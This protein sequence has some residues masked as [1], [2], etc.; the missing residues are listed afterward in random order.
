MAKSATERSRDWRRKN[1]KKGGRSL[2]VWLEP[3]TARKLDELTTGETKQA[4]VI[5]KAIDALYDVACNEVVMPKNPSLF[6][7]LA[8]E[9]EMPAPD[10]S[11]GAPAAQEADGLPAC[12]AEIKIRV[13]QGESVADMKK[14]FA[15]AAKALTDDGLSQRKIANLLNDAGFPTFSGSGKWGKTTIGRLLHAT[16]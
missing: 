7:A 8:E 2:S 10:A 14:A 6:E 15:E 16:T 11:A 5:A 4:D 9:K 3:E 13:D 12:L 1:A